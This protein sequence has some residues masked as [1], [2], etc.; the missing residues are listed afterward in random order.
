MVMALKRV[1]ITV[2]SK[3]H[4][5]VQDAGLNLSGMVREKLEDHFSNHVITIAVSKQLK[6]KYDKMMSIT[7]T[8]DEELMPY[9]NKAINEYL[10][11]KKREIDSTI[12]SLIKKKS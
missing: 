3:L 12:D 9:L 11:N 5:K 2:D 7:N 8:T 1:N 4:K 6:E 10:K